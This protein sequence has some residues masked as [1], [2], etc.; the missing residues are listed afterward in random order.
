CKIARL[1]RLNLVDSVEHDHPFGYVGGV[2][3]KFAAFAVATA[4]FENSLHKIDVSGE[5]TPLAC[6]RTSPGVRE[7]FS[8][9]NTLRENN[10]SENVRCGGTP[11]P[12][13]GTRAVPNPAVPPVRLISSPR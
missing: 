4:D 3:T 11:Q 5:R 6:W 2:L 9:A 1:R 7:L 10:V 8:V 12:V 13:R